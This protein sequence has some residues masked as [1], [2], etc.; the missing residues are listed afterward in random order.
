MFYKPQPLLCFLTQVL[1]L[2]TPTMR[3]LMKRVTALSPTLHT[4]WGTKTNLTPSFRYYVWAWNL[5][6]LHEGPETFC[7]LARDV[8][9]QLL[10]LLQL[11]LY[12]P[13]TVLSHF[14]KDIS[15]TILSSSYNCH[16][17]AEHCLGLKSSENIPEKGQLTFSGSA[18]LCKVS[19]PLA[20]RASCNFHSHFWL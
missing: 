10:K 16:N 20:F 18:C 19:L 4:L 1:I 3:P 11:Q 14:G 13:C 6:L 7:G 17:N 15:R 2:K 9:W 12:L 8:S 5:S